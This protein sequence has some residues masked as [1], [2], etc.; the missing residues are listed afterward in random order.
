LLALFLRS[1]LILFSLTFVS[2]Y[3]AKDLLIPSEKS[4]LI[5]AILRECP[6]TFNSI[7]LLI[8]DDGTKSSKKLFNQL[9]QTKSLKVSSSGVF[10]EIHFL[11]LDE[12]LKKLPS[13][14]MVF[15]SID[16]AKLYKNYKVISDKKA[17]LG[18]GA[19]IVLSKNKSTPKVYLNLDVCRKYSLTFPTSFMRFVSIYKSEDES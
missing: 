16:D 13:Y 19:L 8:I 4:I 11:T 15:S 3:E 7:R 18:R 6:I 14:D 1:F 5:Q 12:V 10:L 9:N 2:V 17:H